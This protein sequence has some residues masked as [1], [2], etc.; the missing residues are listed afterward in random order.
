MVVTIAPTR[1]SSVPATRST[2]PPS[3]GASGIIIN[4]WDSVGA[5]R[6]VELSGPIAKG[7]VR[8]ENVHELGDI[9]AGKAAL[10]RDP[11]GI[12]FYKNNTGLAMQFARRHPAQEAPGRGH[13]PHHPDGVVRERK[14]AYLAV[15]NGR[16]GPATGGRPGLTLTRQPPSPRPCWPC[17]RY[18]YTG[19]HCHGRDG[20][21]PGARTCRA[22]GAS[23]GRAQR[24]HAD[25]GRRRSRDRRGLAGGD[26]PLDP[27]R[28][29]GALGFQEPVL[30][31]LPI[32]R[33]RP[34]V[35]RVAV[36]ESVSLWRA[37]ECRR[38]AVADLRA[39]DGA[40]CAVRSG[41][42][43]A[44]LRPPGPRASPDRRTI[45]RRDR[46]PRALA[47]RRLRAGGGGV[48]VRRRC[49]G[50]AAAHRASS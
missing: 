24:I 45:G 32:P 44:R 48:H 10:R 23:L 12:V 39:A 9:V 47:R 25:A 15:R 37:S 43:A 20:R 49:G 27:E 17:L 29:R 1:T 40:V 50:A 3:R 28:Q 42:V 8:R 18:F 26:E 30:R 34:G 7:M 11:G 4:D 41:A 36:L 14:A 19:T 6:Q 16:P 13:Q 46:C 38:S 35:R 21:T 5:N 33:V 31:L 2:R 22:V